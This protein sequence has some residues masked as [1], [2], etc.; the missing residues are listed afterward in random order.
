MAYPPAEN[1][2]SLD[3]HWLT[4]TFLAALAAHTVVQLWL[5]LRQSRHVA[6]HR[7][8]VPA[9]FADSVSPAEHAKAADYTV[10]RHRLSRLETVFDVAVLLVMTLGGGIQQLGQ[11]ATAVAGPL[12][13]VAG[14]LHVL[15]VLLVF[16][17]LGLPFS[18]WRTFVLEQRFGFNRTT[19]AVFVADLFKAL[20]LGGLLGGA[21]VA[22]VLW[23]MA[24]A[25]G[26]WWLVAWAAWMSFS[27]LLLWA[28]PRWIAGLFNKFT[29]LADAAA[30]RADR[31]PAGALRLSCAGGLRHGRLEAL[32]PR[33]RLFHRPG[34]R[35]AH[36]LLR[37]AAAVAD[38]AAGR[39]GAGA[40]AGALQAA[41]HPA[42]HRGQRTHLVCGLC[43]ARLAGAARLVLPRAGRG[44]AR[45][46]CGRA[47]VCAGAAGLYLGAVAAGRRLVAAPRIRG[48]RLRRPLQQRAGAGA[49]AG[50]PVS[51]ER[52]HADA[53]PLAF[54]R[55]TIPTRRRSCASRGC[56]PASLATPCPPPRDSPAPPRPRRPSQPRGRQGPAARQPPGLRGGILRAPCRGPDRRYRRAPGLQGARPQDRRGRRRR[57]DAGARVQHGAGALGGGRAAPPPQRAAADRQPRP[58]RG[59]RRQPRPAGDRG[60]AAPG[61]RPLHHRP[62]P[63]RAP[64]TPASSRC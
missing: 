17:L 58:D 20:V 63:G 34:A 1:H 37:H 33:Q 24:A 38:A 41:P 25:G 44:A 23:T 48:R 35:E 52:Q 39:G 21:L 18:L 64:A 40:R 3:L 43:P 30:A 7:Q 12:P 29:P 51:R 16:S 46:F 2:L 45:Q 22:V 28:W 57:G 60:R 59:H 62:L 5:S 31:C 50:Q 8:Q 32:G 36:R 19:P 47:A 49:C 27:L 13:L 55:S 26:R 54:G 42:A 10:A 56:W 53:R 9:A 11:W 61:L 4:L 15:L 6:S 14:T